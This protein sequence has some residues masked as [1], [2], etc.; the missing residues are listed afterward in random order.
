MKCNRYIIHCDND[1]Y[2]TLWSLHNEE[3]YLKKLHTTAKTC[4]M[5]KGLQLCICK[6]CRLV[7]GKHTRKH[8]E[9]DI[10]VKKVSELAR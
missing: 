7:T 5:L 9:S 8:N 1:D 3:T 4:F 6:I 10:K 2:R